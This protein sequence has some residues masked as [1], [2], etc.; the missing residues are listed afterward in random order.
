MYGFRDRI[1]GR[2]DDRREEGLENPRTHNLQRGITLEAL[3]VGV[4]P[5]STSAVAAVNLD[6]ELELLESGRHLAPD[7]IIEKIIEHGK[8]VVVTSDKEKMPSKVEKIASSLGAERFNPGEDLEVERKRELGEGDNSHERDASASAFN[9]Y[10]NLQR[11]IRKIEDQ[12]AELGTTRAEAAHRYFSDRPLRESEEQE[13]AEEEEN[14]EPGEPDREKKRMERRIE[15][16]EDKVSRLNSELGEREKENEK[17]REKLAELREGKKDEVIRDREIRKRE[18]IIKD[19]N[20]E[21]NEL[22]EELEKAEIR[23]RQ[24]RKALERLEEGGELVPVLDTRDEEVPDKAVT[25]SPQLQ[26]RLVE[27]GFNV[28]HVEELEGVE[29]GDY[30]VVEEFP[31]KSFQK[32]I[33]EYRKSR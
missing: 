22:E 27:Q 19:K 23:N 7:E 10:N 24:Y 16:L 9:A 20:A 32:V 11:E 31:E 4:D 8:P 33:E 30:M 21:I 6:G 12:A 29:L 13:E 14:P 25:R 26:E 17:L 1:N 15:R 28:K 5:G 18:G 3:I 2:G